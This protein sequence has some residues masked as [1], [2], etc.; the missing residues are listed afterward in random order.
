MLKEPNVPPKRSEYAERGPCR[1]SH[2]KEDTKKP[3]AYPDRYEEFTAECLSCG[4]RI[5]LVIGTNH[6]KMHESHVTWARN[7]LPLPKRM[8]GK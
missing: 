1:G 7:R 6:L 3:T 2:F 8:R 5:G 4:Q